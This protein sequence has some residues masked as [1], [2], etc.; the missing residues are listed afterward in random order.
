MERRFMW[1]LNFHGNN[2]L[3]PGV[4]ICAQFKWKQKPCN[5]HN[6]PHP[7]STLATSDVSR[8]KWLI[9]GAEYSIFT[10]QPLDLPDRT[11]GSKLEE[12]GI[13]G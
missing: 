13:P 7:H 12:T 1:F 4:F 6:T 2:L 10:G 5:V 11:G 3:K 8:R 9:P